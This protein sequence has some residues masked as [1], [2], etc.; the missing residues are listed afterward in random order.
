MDQEKPGCR[1]TVGTLTVQGTTI[2]D[3]FFF[4]GF[5][6]PFLCLPLQ[7]FALGD[8]QRHITPEHTAHRVIRALRPLHSVKVAIHRVRIG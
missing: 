2:Y 5:L 1:S 8:K 4:R 3:L 7:L 6:E